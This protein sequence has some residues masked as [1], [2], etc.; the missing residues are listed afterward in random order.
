MYVS[1]KEMLQ[2]AR[3]GGYAVGAFNIVNFLTAQATVKAAEEKKSP[4]IIQTSVA[5]VKQIGPKALIAFLRQLAEDASVPVAVHLDHCTDEA[6]VMQCLALGWS[7]VMIDL[8]KAAFEVNVEA[9]RR[10]VQEAERVGATVEGELGA[11]FGVED[12][13]KVDSREASLA[14][15]KKSIEYCERTGVSVFAPAIGTAH[16]LYKGVPVVAFDLLNTIVRS[17]DVPMVVHGGTGL[18]TEVF[19]RLIQIGAAKINIS[20]AVKIAYCSA[21]H[22]YTASHPAENNPLKLDAYALD[23]TMQCVKDHI[24]IFGSTGRA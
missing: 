11:I 7:S 19:Q 12:D 16:G 4:L 6:L 24:A 22:D 2:D 9:T 3:T 15:P 8:S 23:K 1:M 14:D 21:M 18:S 20:T 10:V 5:S 17:I 13:I